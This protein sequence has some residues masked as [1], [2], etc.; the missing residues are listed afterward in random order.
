MAELASLL[1]PRL[2]ERTS[3]LIAAQQTHTTWEGSRPVLLLERCW[4]RL[5]V[6]RVD[7]LAQVLPPDASGE[8]PELERFRALR[9]AGQ[10]SQ[11]AQ[12]QCW[13]EFGREACSEALRRFWEVQDAGNHGWTLTHYLRLLDLYRRQVEAPGPSPVPLL[14]LARRGSDEVHQLQWCWPPATPMRHT[15]P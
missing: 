14:V 6:V 5:Q 11:R 9:Q 10:S 3:A 12:E 7:E 2:Q 4:L 1:T 15:C 13:E 8:A